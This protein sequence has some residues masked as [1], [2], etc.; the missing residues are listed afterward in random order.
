MQMKLSVFFLLMLLLV[1]TGLEDYGLSVTSPQIRKD[2]FIASLIT[3]DAVLVPFA[4]YRQGHWEN[5]WPKSSDASEKEPNTLASLPKPWFA[6]GRV[7]SPVWYFW[8][9]RG[10][11]HFL[12]AS[13]IVEV[14]SHCQTVWGIVSDLPK[15]EAAENRYGIVGVALDTNRKVNPTYEVNK[16]QDE[17]SEVYSFVQSEFSKEEKN[18]ATELSRFLKPPP[19]EEQ[20]NKSITLS[21][22]YQMT[23]EDTGERLYYFESLKEYR[24]PIP[25]NAQSCNDLFFNGWISA[26]SGEL[27]LTDSKVGWTDCE[28]NLDSIPLGLL[29]LDGEVFIFVRNFGYEDEEYLIFKLSDSRMQMVLETQGGSC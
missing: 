10:K 4:Q 29:V 7:P 1:F 25:T 15:E 11:G 24:K 13:R 20:K 9:P 26:K 14:E 8:S 3:S 12:N 16:T 21:H 2:D 17:W 23:I 22:L 18:K 19:R 28:D 5:P 6:E 27:K